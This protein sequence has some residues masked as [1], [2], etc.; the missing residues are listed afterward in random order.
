MIETTTGR[1]V[2]TLAM[3]GRQQ[4]D[5]TGPGSSPRLI[6]HYRPVATPVLN[7]GKWHHWV[8][9]G[10]RYRLAHD[11]TGWR[12]TCDTWPAGTHIFRLATPDD[13]FAD[14]LP[15]ADGRIALDLG[16]VYE[17]RPDGIGWALHEVG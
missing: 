4:E 6:V 9:P 3:E 17:I 10:E 13:A 16:K 15:L 5:V 11:G 12:V 2:G 7:D 14:S 1:K 8:V